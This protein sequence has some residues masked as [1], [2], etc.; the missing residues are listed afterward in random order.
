MKGVYSWLQSV[1][2][3]FQGGWCRF[4]APGNGPRNQAICWSGLF[5]KEWCRPKRARRSASLRC[6]FP[7]TPGAFGSSLRNSFGCP[8]GKEKRRG[9][10]KRGEKQSGG[11][12][13]ERG[14]L[15]TR[16]QAATSHYFSHYQKRVSKFAARHLWIAFC[17]GVSSFHKLLSASPCPKWLAGWR[18]AVKL[19]CL[20]QG[21]AVP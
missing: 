14:P 7:D 12:R 4:Q 11:R 20:P 21:G 2:T 15:P 10:E 5:R 1:D 9:E 19:A 8:S 18:E 6:G 17:R 3:R 16:L 13:V